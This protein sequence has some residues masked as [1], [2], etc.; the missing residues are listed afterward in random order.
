MNQRH[1]LAQGQVMYVDTGL[2]FAASDRTQ[3]EIGM[4]F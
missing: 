1:E 4:V 3:L 2:F